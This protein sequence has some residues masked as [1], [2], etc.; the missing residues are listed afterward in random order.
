MKEFLQNFNSVGEFNYSV[1]ISDEFRFAHFNN[2]K[3][4]CT[5]IKASL[6]MACAAA[7]GRQLEYTNIGDIHDRGRN[8]LLKPNSITADS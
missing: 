4:A 2:P 8:V 1:H 3:C 6:N 5:T 7:L